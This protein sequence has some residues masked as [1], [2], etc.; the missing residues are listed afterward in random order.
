MRHALPGRSAVRIAAA[1]GA[2]ALGASPSAASAAPPDDPR[3]LALAGGST[4]L[5]VVG[6]EYRSPDQITG[7]R[8][9]FGPVAP[10]PVAA[11]LPAAVR[12]RSR[13]ESFS[14]E[15]AFA[16]RDGD[17]YVR[18]ATVGRTDPAE[19]WR[20]LELPECLA[21]RVRAISA[22]HRLLIALDPSG[23]IYSHDMSGGD[24]SAERWTWRWGPYFWTGSGMRMPADV[25]FWAT[26]EFTSAETFTDSS[27]RTQNPIGVA[28]V[29]LL[30]AGGRRITYLD[31]WLPNDESREVCGPRRGTVAL[32]ALS[33]SG[34]TVLAVSRR[35]EVFTRLYDFDV[36]GANTV[37]GSYSW[38]QDRPATDTRWQLPGPRWVRQRTPPGTITDRISIAKTGDD[39]RDRL[40]RIEGRTPRGRTGYWEKPL[41]RMGERPWRFVETGGRLAGRRLSRRGRSPRVTPADRRY[42]G[43]IAGAPAEVVN[44]N[45]ECSPATLRVRIAP[46]LPLDLI[47]HSSDGLRQETRG[48]G[49]DDTPREYNGA[50]E[51]PRHVHDSL[52][53]RD[54]RVRAWI[55]EHLGTR[56]FTTA[57]IAVT[58]TRMRFLAQCWELTLEGRPARPDRPRIPPD[59]G[60]AI[61]RFTEQQQDGRSPSSC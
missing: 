44:F 52:N 53:R 6:G 19:P 22:D 60:A 2:I 9:G 11:T 1:L 37:F 18:P 32:A 42:A 56:R 4:G 20:V 33:G 45:A 38:E 14:R 47:L 51:V 31:P 23:Q 40:L 16:L 12:F 48:Q 36:A 25:R 21:G 50:I 26:S 59:M 58:A 55:S 49:L 35:A 8:G 57:P 10:A 5:L 29:Y 41:A 61:G 24:L 54:P 17:I 15:Y 43:A 30:R 39:A 28:T 3:C 7:Q 27:G 46:G 13:T 34:S